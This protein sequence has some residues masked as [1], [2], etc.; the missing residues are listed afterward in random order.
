MSLS[1]TSTYL[2]NTSRDGNFLAACLITLPMKKCFLISSLNIP[3]HNLR[4]LPWVWEERLTPSSLQAS[5]RYLKRTVLCHLLSLLCSRLNKSSSFSCSLPLY[6]PPSCL[7]SGYKHACSF[8]NVLL[9]STQLNWEMGIIISIAVLVIGLI[10]VMKNFHW[11][12][13]TYSL[14]KNSQIVM[15]Q[16]GIEA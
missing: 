14:Q 16:T 6:V 11:D 2:L 1:D 9:I 3:W 8:E 4:P 12:K 5:F 15:C 13:T 7:W 10:G